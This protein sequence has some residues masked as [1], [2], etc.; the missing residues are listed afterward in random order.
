LQPHRTGDAAEA[1]ADDDG[2][3]SING[4]AALVSR[5]QTEGK[6]KSVAGLAARW[7]TKPPSAD[8]AL[9]GAIAKS[10]TN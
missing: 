6:A 8:N 7:N 10:T 1:R 5:S 2:R 4:H 9:P 3:F